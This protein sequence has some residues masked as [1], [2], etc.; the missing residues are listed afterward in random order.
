MATVSTPNPPIVESTQVMR[1]R[2]GTETYVV[3][4]LTPAASTGRVSYEVY[5]TVPDSDPVSGFCIS[6]ELTDRFLTNDH[7]FVFPVEKKMMYFVVVTAELATGPVTVTWLMDP[8]KRRVSRSEVAPA[9]VG[10][11]E[12]GSEG[13]PPKKAKKSNTANNGN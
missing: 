2:T 1:P 3:V 10:G 13:P 11:V 4:T 8:F 6:G 9:A 12:G 5:P 7:S